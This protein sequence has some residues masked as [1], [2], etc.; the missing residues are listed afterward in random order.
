LIQVPA[1]RRD[2]LKLLAAT[3]VLGL[4]GVGWTHAA[5]LK[6][7]ERLLLFPSTAR[8]LHANRTLARVEL[9]VYEAE[10]RPGASQIFARYLG[11]DLSD[12]SREDRARYDS[13]TRLF[14]VD[15]ESDR[16]L[17]IRIGSAAPV[18]L[19]PSDAN[20]RVSAEVEIRAGIGAISAPTWIDYKVLMRRADKRNFAGRFLVLPERGVGVVSDIDDTIKV[21][22][23][24]NQREMLLNTFAREF[25]AVPGMSAWM[26]RCAMADRSISF[27]YVS[28]GP[29]QLYPAL[30]RFLQDE[31]FPSG[32]VHLRTVDLVQEVFSSGAG[33]RGHKMATISRLMSD[34]P[35]R[36]FV[37]VGDS[38][39]QDPEIYGELARMHGGQIAAIYIRDVTGEDAGAPRY[40]QAT[41][42]LP[43]ELWNVFADA[44][45]LP[46][47]CF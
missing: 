39:E 1:S 24:R 5:G 36:R 21:T 31:S 16:A 27:H 26:R 15:S 23:V 46:G 34:F 14:R 37:L 19:P 42:G 47:R 8:R 9:W 40:A 33:T 28:G 7:D 6:S 38:G 25:V 32:T 13:R 35:Q 17:Q 29:F 30:G 22:Q 43:R 12:L 2:F 44:S 20:G 10:S 41:Q 11:L 18:A 45:Q 3:P 4:G